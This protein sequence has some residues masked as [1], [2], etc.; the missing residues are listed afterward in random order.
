MLRDT[1]E[2]VAVKVQR[3]GV[4]ASIALDVF[5]LR[6]VRPLWQ[7]REWAEGGR[8]GKGRMALQGYLQQ[9]CFLL[10]HASRAVRTQ[11]N[12]PRLCPLQLLAALRQWRK[13][14][15]DLPAL[16]DEWASSL[17]RELDYRHEA[18]NGVRFRELYGHLEVGRLCGGWGGPRRG[19]AGKTVHRRSYVV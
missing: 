19:G 2:A 5:V 3:P 17:F 13:V 1:G 4:A 15:S 16:L 14:N 18:A 10:I 7:G 8:S 12:R 11:L 9:L 6:Q